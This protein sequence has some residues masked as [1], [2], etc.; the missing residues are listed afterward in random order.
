MPAARRVSSARAL[1][2]AVASGVARHALADVLRHRCAERCVARAMAAAKCRD[3]RRG[4]VHA[5][6]GEAVV[7]VTRAHTTCK[8]PMVGTW[9][10]RI[11]GNHARL[12]LCIR[13]GRRMD[14]STRANAASKLTHALMHMRKRAVECASAQDARPVREVPTPA[15][16]HLVCKRC[17]RH[18]W[19]R[20][21][22][23]DALG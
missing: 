5:A 4:A 1:D 11:D 22:R 3:A 6:V 19:R 13:D 12:V 9:A 14:E 16:T 17:D 8:I 23:L 20:S 18:R 2:A 7:G 21:R 15:N 10:V